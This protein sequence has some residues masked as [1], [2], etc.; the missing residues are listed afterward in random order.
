MITVVFKNRFPPLFAYRWSLIYSLAHKCKIKK[1]A[2]EREREGDRTKT[3]AVEVRNIKKCL[4]TPKSHK[5]FFPEKMGC[6]ESILL[7]LIERR[8]VTKS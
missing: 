6:K 3:G 2:R 8:E 7:I 1:L 5:L 4:E